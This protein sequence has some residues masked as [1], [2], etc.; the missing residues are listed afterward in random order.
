MVSLYFG[1]IL[2]IGHGKETVLATRL[3]RTF[4]QSVAHIAIFDFS[5][6]SDAFQG[7]R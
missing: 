5:F 6:V 4:G 7:Q 1:Q 2:V 3:K